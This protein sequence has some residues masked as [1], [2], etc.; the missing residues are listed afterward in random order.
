MIS[1][2]LRDYPK[3]CVNLHTDVRYTYE[4]GG[5]YRRKKIRFTTKGS[6]SRSDEQLYA[7]NQYDHF[8][9]VKLEFVSKLMIVRT[10][11]FILSVFHSEASGYRTELRKS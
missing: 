4:Y 10:D 9:R 8:L 2:K 3:D 1:W 6:S 11:V 7:C 5:F